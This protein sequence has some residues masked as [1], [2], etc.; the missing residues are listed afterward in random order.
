MRRIGGAV[1]ATALLAPATARA[2]RGVF[3]WLYDTNV[4]EENNVE[5]ESRFEELDVQFASLGDHQTIW[6]LAPIVGLVEGLELALP[7]ESQWNG[8]DNPVPGFVAGSTVPR[9]YGAELRYRFVA[10]D[11]SLVPF[12]RVAVKH[13]VLGAVR[14]EADAVLSFDTWRIHAAADAGM[15]GDFS[16]RDSFSAANG[17]HHFEFHPG[18]GISVRAIDELRVGAELYGQLTLD[19]NENGHTWAAVGPDVA[20]ARGR[21]WV[22][23]AY[24][25]GVYNIH[26][27]PRV[28]LG[29]VL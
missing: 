17:D 18:L 7:V 6:W 25:F 12:A 23:A 20:W 14:T 11:A 22:A 5:I 4:V 27:A 8:E 21:F 16:T 29:I 15:I 2:G 28:W 9:R 24:G 3:G 26:A 19:Q 13:D 10:R 1:L